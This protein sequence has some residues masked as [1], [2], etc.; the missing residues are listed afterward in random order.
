AAFD[1]M[2]DSS[3]H[4]AV[5][6]RAA[7]PASVATPAPEDEDVRVTLKNHV[8][9]N[10]GRASAT[11]QVQERSPEVA[12][13]PP[14]PPP[15]A[16]FHEST[17]QPIA[18]AAASAAPQ[19]AMPPAAETRRTMQP[20]VETQRA[21]QPA[22][23][24]QGTMQ[25]VSDPGFG[26]RIADEMAAMRAMLSEQI[27]QQGM[28]EAMRR[29]PLRARAM[30]ELLQAGYSTALARSLVQQMPDDYSPAQARDWMNEMLARNLRCVAA[31]DDLVTRGGIYALVGPTGVG[32]TTTTAKLA[33]RC[34]VRYGASRLALFTTDSYRVGAHDQL[35]IYA[36]ILGV[37][38]QTIGELADL[39]QALDAARG[40]HLVLI[41][42][43]GMGQRD[44]RL[45]EQAA[46]LAEPE[47]QRVLLLNASTQA[48]TLE[49][50]AVR[51]GTAADGTALPFFGTILT[52]LD[53]AAC[54][55]PALDVAIRH[56]LA[57]QCVTHG[58]R[59]PEDLGPAR[60]DYLVGR[61]LRTTAKPQSTFSFSAGELSKPARVPDAI[62]A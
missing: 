34:A 31:E 41:D 55:G 20:V 33:A 36:R 43:V 16:R 17:A 60:G 28:T 48:E 14:L 13:A 9:R 49:E 23:D 35:R 53:E 32:K 54:L 12:V 50:V 5:P 52:K 59:V 44:A 26:Q 4:A 8:L 1:G 61:S 22:A 57:L 6:A 24:M 46:L 58:Q 56:R 39:R 27:E 37:T 40:K 21:L 51:Y 7:R 25:P 18:A 30:R 38:V 45:S 29:S 3:A 15:V 62:H 10:G 47:I 11:S 2:L 19:K 42:T